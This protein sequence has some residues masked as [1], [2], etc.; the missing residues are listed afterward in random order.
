M[1]NFQEMSVTEL[2]KFLS[3]NRNN[4]QLFSEALGEILKRNQQ[5]KKY[6]ANMS[7][8]EIDQIVNQKIQQ[9]KI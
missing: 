2:K 1:S 4:E 3:L 7:S 5:N 8:Q 9:L 6:C